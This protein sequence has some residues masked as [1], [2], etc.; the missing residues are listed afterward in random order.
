MYTDIHS[1]IVPK[2]DDGA[3]S[4]E[5]ALSLLKLSVAEGAGQI[6]ATPHFYASSQGLEDRLQLVYSQFELLKVAVADTG[7]DVNVILGFEVRYFSGISAC[8]ELDRLC[9][10]G[11][12]FI[13]LELGYE[14]ISDKVISEIMELYYQGYSV[15][16]AHLER[17][18]RLRGFSK[19]KPLIKNKYVY[20]QVNA[21]SFLG[22]P[23]VHIAF[24]LLKSGMVD[25]VAGDMHSLESRPPRIKE[26]LE[27]IEKKLG[28]SA[29][30]RL[31]IRSNLLFEK[32]G[33][34]RDALNN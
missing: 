14:P 11:S 30:R 6:I 25:Y 7:L 5:E 33:E 24:R 18:S 17:Y 9:I 13:L 3:K 26:A 10:A 15:I 31:I 23:F 34:G 12:R 4:I 8:D 28:P 21:A 2:V 20:V 16:L 1:H 29:K 32:I 22:G 19:L 27:V